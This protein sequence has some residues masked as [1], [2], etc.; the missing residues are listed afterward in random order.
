MFLPVGDYPN[1][2][3]Y[4]AWVTWGLMAVNIAIFLLVS[5]P[6][7]G[8]GTYGPFVQQFGYVPARP[9]IVSLFTSMFLH[10]GFMHLAGNMLFLYIFGDN[11]EHRLGRFWYLLVYLATGA[12]GTLTFGMLDAGSTIPLVGASGAISGVLGCYF[13]FFPRNVVK[14]AI[15]LFIFF[16]VL[17]IPA[18][19]VL[20]FYVIVQN[21]LPLLL[22]AESN[23]AY[24]AH[25]GGFVAGAAVAFIV[26]RA[27]AGMVPKQRKQPK[28]TVKAKVV[29]IGDR[30]RP[31]ETAGAPIDQAV[32]SGDR[33]RAMAAYEAMGPI[34]IARDHPEAA[35]VIADWLAESGQTIAAGDLLRKVLGNRSGR[36]DQAR[37]YLVLGL[38][39]LKQGQL[40]AAYQHLMSVLDFDPDEETE[41]RARAALAKIRLH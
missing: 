19:W 24:G 21:L 18:R 3:G 2:P 13:V 16:Q 40:V 15:L 23:V 31:V 12:L 34:V 11:V 29:R 8:Q 20:G 39:R 7:S 27:V 5:L 6:L 10:G 37:V 1:P 41:E 14:V 4:K 30:V 28:K 17:H 9:S 36:V 35:L 25:F 26:E 38:I 32:A 22:R 33:A